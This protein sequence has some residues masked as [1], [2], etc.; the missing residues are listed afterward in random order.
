M[1]DEDAER[2]RECIRGSVLRSGYACDHN[3]HADLPKDFIDAVFALVTL[4]Q[5][6]ARADEG[7][8]GDAETKGD[9]R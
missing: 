1:D 6:N 2:V 4:C 3:I 8:T 5:A 9:L 7:T